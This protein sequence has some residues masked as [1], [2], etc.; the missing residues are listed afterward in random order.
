MDKNMKTNK[1]LQIAMMTTLLAAPLAASAYELGEKGISAA[2]AKLYSQIGYDSTGR[3]EYLNGR[4]QDSLVEVSGKSAARNGVRQSG[5]Q[6]AKQAKGK[7]SEYVGSKKWKAD[8]RRDAL[9]AARKHEANR[10]A[11]RSIFDEYL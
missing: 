7:K 11:G 9:E 2:D 4:A 5:K 6:V 8:I 1:I 3:Y 10:K